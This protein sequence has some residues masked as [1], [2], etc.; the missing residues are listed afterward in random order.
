[1]LNKKTC[2]EIGISAITV[3]LHHGRLMQKMQADSISP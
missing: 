3:K 1:M 2:N